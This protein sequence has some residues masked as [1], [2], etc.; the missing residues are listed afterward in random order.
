MLRE[1]IIERI[2]GMDAEDL[3]LVYGY[4]DLIQKRPSNQQTAPND[5][6]L[7][8]REALKGLKGSLSEDI[9]AARAER[10]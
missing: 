1:R 7:Q 5:A 6:H 2:N 4:I 9:L 10:I 8:V 3:M